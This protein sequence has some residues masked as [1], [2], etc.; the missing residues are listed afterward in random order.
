MAADNIDKYLKLGKTTILEC[1]EYYCSSI[2]ECF[3]DE[4]L[5]CPTVA[6][7]QRFLTK[8]EEREFPG[9]LWCIDH[10]H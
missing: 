6:D 3:G 4:F 5:R 2:I 7:T 10:M 1:L 9:I 8:A